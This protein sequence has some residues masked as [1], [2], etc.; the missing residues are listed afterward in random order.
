[1]CAVL[2]KS[3]FIVSL[4][5]E[6]CKQLYLS[7]CSHP[8]LVEIQITSFFSVIDCGKPPSVANSSFL[9]QNT[10][11]HSSAAY[12]CLPGYLKSS[13][14][15]GTKICNETGEWIGQDIVCNCEHRT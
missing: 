14:S 6:M 11:L 7:H 10:T 5:G 13:S 1:M 12:A 9:A 15:N 4:R 3:T 8:S 2:N